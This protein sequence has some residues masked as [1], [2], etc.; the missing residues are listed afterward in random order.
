MMTGQ[1]LIESKQQNDRWKFLEMV[2]QVFVLL[3]IIVAYSGWHSWWN[4]CFEFKF[5]NYNG[6]IVLSW[7]LERQK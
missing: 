2:V 6:K 4:K 5:F 3:I 1:Q 7:K